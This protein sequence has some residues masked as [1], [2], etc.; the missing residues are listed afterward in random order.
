MR[1]VVLN[2]GLHFEKT[3]VVDECAAEDVGFSGGA[4]VDVGFLVE[5]IEVQND[6]K[7]K[8]DDGGHPIQGKHEGQTD[9]AREETQPLIV[10]PESWTPS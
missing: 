5:Y 9:G 3:E 2:V 6:G 4:P 7:Y 10:V 1:S 8:D